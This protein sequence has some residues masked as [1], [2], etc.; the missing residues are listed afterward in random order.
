MRTNFLLTLAAGL[1]VL[2]V[3]TPAASAKPPLCTAS[4]IEQ[5]L[6]GAGK[7]TAEDVEG[8]IAVSL[9]RCGDVTD[10]GAS[11]VVFTLASGGTAGDT[12]FGVIEGGADGAGEVVLF[13]QGYK[14]GIARH[15]SDSFDVLQPALR[16]ARRQLLPELLP[17]DP[18]HVD[19]RT[20]QGRQGEEAALRACALLPPNL[21]GLSLYVADGREVEA[22][23]RRGVA[24]GGAGGSFEE[25]REV[26][27]AALGGLE[28]G[29]DEDPVHVAH[30]ALGFDLEGQHVAVAGPAGAVDRALEALVVGLRRREGGEVVRAGQGGRAR[31]QRVLVEAVRPPEGLAALEGRRRSAGED[32]VAVGPARRVVAGGEALRGLLGAQHDDLA[33]QHRVHGAQPRERAVVGDDLA[34]RVHAAVGPSRHTDVDGMSEDYLE[35]LNDFGGHRPQSGLLSPARE[36]TAVVLQRELGAQTSSR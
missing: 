7:L 5:T 19:R 22:V 10:D 34:E 1:G 24:G 30:E 28:H 18:L 9:I 25:A 3:L 8:G 20:V 13:K 35:C 16:Q 36:G 31:V 4:V 27:A 32:A 33:R 26:V 11:D 2:T 29:A 23:R 14:V 17:P 21:K 12:R 6:I 15:D